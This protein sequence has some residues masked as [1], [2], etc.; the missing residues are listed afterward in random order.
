MRYVVS[1]TYYPGGYETPVVA[2][3]RAYLIAELAALKEAVPYVKDAAAL[4]SI[5]LSGDEL[6]AVSFAILRAEVIE[7]STV[8]AQDG[9][10]FR[11][12][13][14]ATVDTDMIEDAV[15]SLR[16]KSAVYDYK[17]LRS[18]YDA[19]A[20]QIK[21]LRES[22]ARSD[23]DLSG[24]DDRIRE[25]EGS[26]QAAQWTEKAYR[27]FILDD[28][29]KAA[30]ACANSV[31]L[32][33]LSFVAYACRARAYDLKGDMT[34]AALDINKACALGPAD[35][36]IFL[37]RGLLLLKKGRTDDAIKDLDRAISGGAA[38]SKAYFYRG[39]ARF[40]KGLYD[41]SIEDYGRTL[42]IDPS[43]AQ[44][45]YMRGAS[46]YMK[47]DAVKA[48]PDLKRSCDMGENDGC[49]MFDLISRA[50]S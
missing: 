7:R 5:E 10:G 3:S 30:Q 27:Y 48:L 12:E 31:K 23:A 45:R 1:A 28:T 11:L 18:A 29:E 32:A 20:A 38:T 14:S 16:T 37:Q 33:P 44:A 34:G 9:D 50:G 13:V 26:F 2:D 35:P 39:N 17:R 22:A 49:K 8:T 24:L 41:L 4:R 43:N 40:L 6:E 15:R 36:G 46:Y 25:N 19:N 47:K 42:E 21:E